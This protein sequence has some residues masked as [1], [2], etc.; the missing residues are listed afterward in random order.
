MFPA[1]PRS[2]FALLTQSVAAT[3]KVA[4]RSPSGACEWL[5]CLASPH[6]QQ[7]IRE[8]GL[9]NLIALIFRHIANTNDPVS[10]ARLR[11]PRFDD[12]HLETQLIARPYC[13][14]PLQLV[15]SHPNDSAADIHGVD[16]KTHGHRCSVPSTCGQPAK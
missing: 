6:R 16:K 1:A 2:E 9:H 8:K 15:H 5:E 3:C 13:V 14:R 7:C 11:T 12:F 10:R 4:G